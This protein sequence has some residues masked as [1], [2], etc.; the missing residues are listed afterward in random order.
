MELSKKELLKTMLMKK[1]EQDK[2]QIADFLLNSNEDNIE[3]LYSLWIKKLKRPKIN[4]SQEVKEVIEQYKKD[5]NFMGLNTEINYRYN[6]LDYNGEEI[7]Q[8]SID[9]KF[10]LY[11]LNGN[12]D[13]YGHPQYNTIRTDGYNDDLETAKKKLKAEY[14]KYLNP[15]KNKD[16]EVTL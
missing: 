16:I 14:E 11:L 1:I 8:T 7:N 6:K 12:T 15:N 10:S 9:I 4:L 2:E 5:P 13:K 3:H